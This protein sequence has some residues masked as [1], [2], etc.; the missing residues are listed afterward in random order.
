MTERSLR[1]RC[2]GAHCAWRDHCANHALPTTDTFGLIWPTRVED[3]CDW[4]EARR[5]INDKERD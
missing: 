3:A 5:T 1:K 2:T 4:Y